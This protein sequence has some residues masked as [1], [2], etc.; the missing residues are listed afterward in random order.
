MPVQPVRESTPAVPARPSM[1]YA[2]LGDKTVGGFAQ[3]VTVCQVFLCRGGF[4]TKSLFLIS[5][6]C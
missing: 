5:E 1:R 4:C 3:K 2:H 6:L